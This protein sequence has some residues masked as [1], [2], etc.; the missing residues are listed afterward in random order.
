M[1]SVTTNVV[2]RIEVIRQRIEI[3][4]VRHGLVEGRIK[5]GHFGHFRAEE[6]PRGSNG[7]KVIGVVKR[8]QVNAFFDAIQYF[9]RNQSRIAEKFTSMNHAMSDRL[10]ILE[11]VD[12]G[13][14]PR[15]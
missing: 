2:A 14:S 11:G 7:C 6:L 9:V 8:R 3:G 1:E 12:L 13:D 15:I 5:Y 10:Y 4:V